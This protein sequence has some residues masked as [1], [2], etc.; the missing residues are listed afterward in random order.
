MLKRWT[1]YFVI[2]LCALCVMVLPAPQI[3]TVPSDRIVEIQA[4]Q[5]AFSPGTIKVNPGDRVILNLKATDV[6]HGLYI[7]NYGLSMTVDPGQ[8]GSMEFTADQAGTFRFRCSVACGDMHPFMIGKLQVGVN[9]MFWR[10]T[11]L[12]LLS[13]I[14]SIWFSVHRT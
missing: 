10:G 2:G 4:S 3:K 13:V 14:A 9:W 7:D 11:A 12:F 1:P 5:F 8:K 6:V